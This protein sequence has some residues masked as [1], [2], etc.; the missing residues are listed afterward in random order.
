VLNV[1]RSTSDKPRY[2][3]KPGK[4]LRAV[5][6]EV[7]DG[8]EDLPVPRRTFLAISTIGQCVYPRSR[9]TVCWAPL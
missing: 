5:A 3:T 4:P 2:A 6:D 8:Q 1:R 9:Q 7:N